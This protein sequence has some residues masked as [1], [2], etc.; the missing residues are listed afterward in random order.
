MG[1]SL[2][3]RDCLAWMCTGRGA[4]KVVRPCELPPREASRGWMES[5]GQPGKSF[6]RRVSAGCQRGRCETLSGSQWRRQT[7]DYE[8][9]GLKRH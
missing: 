2:V 5:P 7:G 6:K 8:D 1:K 3:G 9:A 4:D